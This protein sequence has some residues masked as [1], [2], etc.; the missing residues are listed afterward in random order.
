MDA[1]A[2]VKTIHILSSTLLFGTGLGTAFFFWRAHAPGNEAGRL[3]AAR[4]TVLAD[5][6][7]T[8]PSV[9]LQ[10]LTGAWLI[11]SGRPALGRAVAGGELRALSAR[12]GL[13]ARGRRYP[14]SHEAHARASGSRGAARRTC[15][16]Q[17]VSSLV[18]ADWP[19]FASL[20]TLFFLMVTKPGW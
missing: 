14:A 16:R 9:V 20:V 5:W 4:T 18:R 7:F 10:P 17:I 1:Y 13:L 3:A 8:T 12:I 19:A 15:L 2:I 11:P 6:L